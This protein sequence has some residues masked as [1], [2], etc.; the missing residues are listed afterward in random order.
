[1]CASALAPVS[2]GQLLDHGVTIDAIALGS[3]VCLLAATGLLQIAFAR[4]AQTRR[5]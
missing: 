1:V 3:A 5:P 2:F 4:Q